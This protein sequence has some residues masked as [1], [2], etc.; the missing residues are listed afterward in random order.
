MG[1]SPLS[2][3]IDGQS[4]SANS[5]IVSSTGLE[6]GLSDRNIP[7]ICFRSLRSLRGVLLFGGGFPCLSKPR[8]QRLIQARTMKQENDEPLKRRG[9]IA[10]S[11]NSARTLTNHRIGLLRALRDAGYSLVAAVPNDEESS[12]LH[13]EGIEVRAMP[14]PAKKFSPIGDLKLLSWYF[15]FLKDL[16]PTV[17]L[18]FGAKPNICGALAGRLARVPVIS[19]A[20]GLGQLFE[21]RWPQRRVAGHFY[22][23][24]FRKAYRVFFESS[25]SRDLFVA[26]GVVRVDQTGLLPGPGID[27][28]RFSPRKSRGGGKKPFT[29]LFASR[30]EWDNGV[31]EYCEAAKLILRD[32]P[33]ARFQLVGA[34]EANT[35]E[36][37]IPRDQL[38]RWGTEGIDYFGAVDDL[39]PLLADADC[40]VVP[41][42]HA[43]GAPRVLVEAA[44]M[45]RP[46]IATEIPGCDEVVTENTTGLFCYPRSVA[47]LLNA[48]RKMM[49]Q[50]PESR[51]E[52]GNRARVKAERQFDERRLINTYLSAIRNMND[53]YSRFSSADGYR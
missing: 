34:P 28:E 7:S 5:I 35:N 19:N 43:D 1:E 51:I 11:A 24:A 2:P 6:S 46:A 47:S 23:T 30:L 48:M 12:R 17:F 16:R 26:G 18:S 45:G 37:A 8:F 41:S 39:R 27:L 25:E 21:K 32:F 40:I 33:L 44:A 31:A 14:R 20:A 52:M 10:V 36:D 15:G 4:A 13:A 9:I 38:E 49:N 50:T 29:F 42:Y 3:L 53:S 22:R